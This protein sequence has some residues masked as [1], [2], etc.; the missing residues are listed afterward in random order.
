MSAGAFMS[1]SAAAPLR[2]LSASQRDAL[3]QRLLPGWR[4]WCAGWSLVRADVRVEPLWGRTPFNS[5]LIVARR[6]RA[7]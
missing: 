4:A 5:Y 6:A 1:S 7:A 2:R 3:A